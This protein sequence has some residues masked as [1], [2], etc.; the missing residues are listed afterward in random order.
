MAKAKE[1]PKMRIICPDGRAENC[2]IITPGGEE[3]K[4]VTGISITIDPQDGAQ[5]W[6]NLFE[7]DVDI[8]AAADV[9]KEVIKTIRSRKKS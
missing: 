9:H 8:V 5:A 6:I 3:L 7:V 1:Q 4:N 2:K